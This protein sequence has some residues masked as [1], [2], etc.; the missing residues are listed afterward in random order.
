MKLS[1]NLLFLFLLFNTYQCVYYALKTERKESKKMNKAIKDLISKYQIELI[2]T[3]EE[4]EKYHHLSAFSKHEKPKREKLKEKDPESSNH[5][6][7]ENK[8]NEKNKNQTNPYFTILDLKNFFNIQYFASIY[9]G[10]NRQKCR[11]IFDTGSNILWVPSANCTHCRNY[12]KKY[13]PLN[14]STSKNLNIQKNI[15]YAIGYVSGN[16]F[17]D[18]ISLNSNNSNYRIYNQELTADNF[19]FLVV[20]EE[21]NLSGTIADGVMGIGINNEGN[22][23]N[24]FIQTLYKENKIKSPSFSFYLTNNKQKSRLYIG[25]ILENDYIKQL[26]SYTK[27]NKCSVPSSSNY[28]LCNIK[29]GIEMYDS[30]YTNT[31]NFQSTSNVI[32]D[33]GTSY[34]IIPRTDFLHIITHLNANSKSDNCKINQNYQLICKCNSPNEFGSFSIK[35]DNNNIFNISFYDVIDYNSK[36]FFQCH[37]QIMVDVFDIHTWI[38]GDSAL[39]SSLITF[40]M[41]KREIKYLQNIN[42]RINK[43]RLATSASIAIDTINSYYYDIIYYLLI[44]VVIFI[45]VSMIIY[46]IY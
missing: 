3:P 38:L 6:H 2:D 33:S 35:F 29:N 36:N 10:K 44:A 30:N 21:K 7:K 32:F 41:E 40:N 11:V 23:K 17:E 12:T 28:W 26:F 45:I 27:F 25:D 20:N 31:Y 1:I 19:R 24:S 14:S 5:K 9:I 34:I 43:L 13:N 22:Y 8:E 39:R 18:S 37:F 4:E 42:E 15:T 16:L 46:L